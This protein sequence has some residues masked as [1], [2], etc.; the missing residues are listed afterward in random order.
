MVNV[1]FVGFTNSSTGLEALFALTNPPAVAVDLYSVRGTRPA[2]PPGIQK[3]RGVFSWARRESWGVAYAISIDTT[4]EPLQVV[5]RFQARSGG[6]RRLVE[7]VGE[8][9]GRLVRR[10]REFFTG[11]IFFETNETRVNPIA[12]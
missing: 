10:D 2:E 11:Q 8:L 5:L 1:A 3:E 4:N 9:L 7:Q 6:P 12:R